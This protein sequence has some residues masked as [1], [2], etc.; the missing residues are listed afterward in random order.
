MRGVKSAVTTYR[1]GT[2]QLKRKS[3]SLRKLTVIFECNIFMVVVMLHV[4][5]VYVF[6]YK[7]AI[8]SSPNS[9]LTSL[10]S[11]P[12]PQNGCDAKE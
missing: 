8:F 10:I 5:V 2:I 7:V 9:I 12:S 1:D 11:T 6:Q 3:N 4:E